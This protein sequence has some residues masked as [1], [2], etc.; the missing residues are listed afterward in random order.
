MHMR[1]HLTD[2]INQNFEEIGELVKNALKCRHMTLEQYLAKMEQSI[3]CGYE[4]TLLILDHMYKTDIAVIRSDKVWMSRD[5][6]VMC[7][8]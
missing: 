5:V 2:Y 7:C 8:P 4:I 6:P 1:H 3:I